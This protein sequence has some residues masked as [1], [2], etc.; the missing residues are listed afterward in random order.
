MHA[1]RLFVAISLAGVLAACSRP[2]SQADEELVRV[3]DLALTSAPRAVVS[4][5][6]L[7]AMPEAKPEKPVASSRIRTVARV[8]RPARPAITETPEPQP[9]EVESPAEE[10]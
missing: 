1:P 2:Q 4:P 5:V 7:G 6:E 9:A 8:V 10:T 3:A